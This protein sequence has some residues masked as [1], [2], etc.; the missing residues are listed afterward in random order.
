MLVRKRT[1]KEITKMKSLYGNPLRKFDGEYYSRGGFT[2]TKT[3]A[4][5][6]AT[7]LRKMGAKARIVKVKDGYMV[8]GSK[9]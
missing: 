4:Q 6:T 7:K 8:W 2:K 1:Q 3:E 9:Q 5:K